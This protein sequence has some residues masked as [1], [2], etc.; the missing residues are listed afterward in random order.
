MAVRSIISEKKD[1]YDLIPIIE[2]W[3]IEKAYSVTVIANRI[4]AEKAHL[5][6]TLFL[7]NYPSG[8]LIKIYSTEEFFN[9]LKQYLMTEHHLTYQIPCP[10]CKRET[11]VSMNNCPYCGGSLK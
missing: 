8:C 4:D 10:Y 2:N 3:L 6:I 7:D 5:S 9:K 1:M 11:D